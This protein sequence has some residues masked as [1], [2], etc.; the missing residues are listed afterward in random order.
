M[1][2]PSYTPK[3]GMIDNRM[4]NENHQQGIQ[5]VIQRGRSMP[6]VAGHNGKMG[7]MHDK[8][9]WSRKGDSLTP[10]KA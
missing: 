9:H 6:D 4:V 10:R 5:R 7:S 3:E 8:A 2:K 1:H